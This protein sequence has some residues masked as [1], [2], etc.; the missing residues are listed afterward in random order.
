MDKSQTESTIIHKGVKIDN[1]CQIAHNVEIGENTVIA[2][3]TG[4]AG[5]TKIGK[6]N[7]VGGQVGF[8]GHI[9]IGDGN[10]FGAQAGVHSN[11]GDGKTVIGYPAVD[12]RSFMRQSAY[13][14]RLGEL[15]DS[16]KELKKQ[17]EE[18]KK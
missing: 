3:Q 10:K 4:I 6:H 14:K 7:M 15:F 16:V 13:L 5:S 2:A 8:A 9:V 1:L 17:M 11:P 18:L 12:A